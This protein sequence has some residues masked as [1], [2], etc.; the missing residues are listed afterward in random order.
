MN[1]LILGGTGYIG[2]ALA[3][4]FSA[5]QHQVTISTR[6]TPRESPGS[7]LRFRHY[8]TELTAAVADAD[9]VINLTG[10]SVIATPWTKAG[11]L[12]II[13]SRVEPA[14]AAVHALQ[15]GCQQDHKPRT[16]IQASGISAY[17]ASADVQ[18]ESSPLGESFLAH[19]C[20]SWEAPALA[21]KEQ[22]TGLPIRVAIIR[23]G[24][25][26][27]P[28]PGT[29][30]A[31]PS[32]AE[33]QLAKMARLGLVGGLAHDDKWQSPIALSDLVRLIMWVNDTEAAEGV[34][35][36]VCPHPIRM[37]ELYPPLRRK[38]G[39]QLPITPPEG[40][41]RLAMGAKSELA[42]SQLRI[43]P[44]RALAAGFRFDHPRPQPSFGS[45][46]PSS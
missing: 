1:I 21:L 41:I 5:A 37:A 26:L 35:N 39:W 23:I 6:S 32:A 2:R 30:P 36:G 4:A 13:N 44:A 11:K 34:Y 42:L 18:D 24:M 28:P 8:P 10:V 45:Q 15:N 20:K 14:L 16:Y 12:A 38:F 17:N 46:N 9:T 43:V 29:A 33:Q 27:G 7:K 22:P 3:A 25:V 19:V 31:N 40:L